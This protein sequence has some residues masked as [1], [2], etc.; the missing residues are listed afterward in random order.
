MPTPKE[1]K[2]A[3]RIT[4]KEEKIR[5]VRLLYNRLTRGFSLYLW[6]TR[7][8]PMLTEHPGFSDEKFAVLAVKNACVESALLS[9][10]DIDD[11]FRHRTSKTRDSDVRA[12]DFFGYRSPGPFLSDE[13]RGSINQWIAHLT[14]E[15][16]WGGNSGI[17]PDSV[18]DWDTAELVGKAARSVFD[19]L[20]HIERELSK[21]EPAESE[22]I[23]TVRNVLALALKNMEA[24]AD[25]ERASFDTGNSSDI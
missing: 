11:F 23:R 18:R 9:V 8:H 1:T 17:A 20:A 10:R 22:G 15:P 24:L 4:T 25:L 3:T 12:E 2:S 19:F 14:Y 5:A 21:E 13:E 6:R 7:V 16:V